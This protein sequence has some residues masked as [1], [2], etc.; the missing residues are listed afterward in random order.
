MLNKLEL[1][2]PPLPLMFVV[3][4]IMWLLNTFLPIGFYFTGQ[5]MFAIFLLV[6]GIL[7]ILPAA[8]SFLKAKTTVDPRTPEKS[9]ILVINGLYK[10][11]RNP[12]YV[13]MVTC[14]FALSFSQG[15]VVSLL[16]SLG[17]ALYLNRFQI[18]PEER[19]LTEKFGE[20]YHEYC[21]NVR[22]WL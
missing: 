13:G 7:F 10:V 22:R 9:N 15:N 14:L 16:M 19:F 20:Q 12:M 2:L 17:F 5:N 11:S 8:I 3:A 6:I 4:A 21:Q 1:L 18:S